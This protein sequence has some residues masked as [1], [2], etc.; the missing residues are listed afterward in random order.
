VVLSEKAALS[1]RGGFSSESRKNSGMNFIS[2]AS[3]R[4]PG[5]SEA[6]RNIRTSPI[7]FFKNSDFSL[8]GEE[9]S[10]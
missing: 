3:P 1:L 8:D 2:G 10:L 4:T 9:L 6:F 7:N 5:C